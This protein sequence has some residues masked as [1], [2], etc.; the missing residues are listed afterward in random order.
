MQTVLVFL[1]TGGAILA[2]LTELPGLVLLG[3]FLLFQLGTHLAIRGVESLLPA[4]QERWLQVLQQLV[5]SL[6]VVMLLAILAVILWLVFEYSIWHLSGNSGGYTLSLA[7]VV[8]SVVPQVVD[9]L[10]LGEALRLVW[11]WWQSRLQNSRSLT[12]SD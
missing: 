12:T 8:V 7:H 10:L 2:I 3:V 4:G 1:T 9:V 11:I 5:A 6:F